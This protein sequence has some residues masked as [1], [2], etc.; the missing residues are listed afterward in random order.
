MS[1]ELVEEIV[2]VEKVVGTEQ[3]YVVAAIV[4]VVPRSIEVAFV[5]RPWIKSSM[6]LPLGI[7]MVLLRIPSRRSDWVIS[8]SCLTPKHPKAC[9]SQTQLSKF[10]APS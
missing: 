8:A 10:V 2:A 6:V 5:V 3:G 9:I 4:E 7:R 1:A